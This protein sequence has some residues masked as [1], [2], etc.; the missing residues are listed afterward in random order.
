MNMENL[1]MGF[2]VIVFDSKN[3]HDSHGKVFKHIW[4][5]FEIFFWKFERYMKNALTWSIFRD[6]KMFV[7]SNW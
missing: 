7:F 3:T 5:A 4:L 2:K 6:R 1:K